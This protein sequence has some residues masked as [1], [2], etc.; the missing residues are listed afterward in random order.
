MASPTFMAAEIDE[1]PQAVS[2]QLAANRNAIAAL[3]AKL[4]ERNPS[5]VVTI[6]RGSSDHAALAAALENVPALRARRAAAVP[7]ETLAWVVAQ[8]SAL[9]LGRGATFG[10]AAEAALKLKETCALHAEA[11]SAAEVLHGPSALVGPGF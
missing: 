6:A 2:H 7:A 9:V 4:R 3:A 10:I 8:R 11:F 1:A 5:V